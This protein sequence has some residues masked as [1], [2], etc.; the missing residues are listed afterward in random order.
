MARSLTRREDWTRDAVGVRR[1]GGQPPPPLPLLQRTNPKPGQ[2]NRQAAAV[3]RFA[4]DSAVSTPS[5]GR[6]AIHFSNHCWGL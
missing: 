6:E 3:S 4:E 5:L 1:S 2:S